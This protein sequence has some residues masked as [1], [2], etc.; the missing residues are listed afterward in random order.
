MRV[1]FVVLL[2]LSGRMPCWSASAPGDVDSLSLA[3]GRVAM[4]KSTALNG[5]GQLHN[6]EKLKAALFSGTELAIVLAALDRQQ[7]WRHWQ[8]MRQEAETPELA[9][10]YAQREDF[11]LRDRN[12]LLWWWMW[13]KLICV[14]DAYV[15]G[16]LSN[17]DAS[18]G[19]ESSLRL[20]V[21]PPDSGLLGMRL[22]A[23]LP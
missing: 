17:F 2:L 20:E 13:A 19:K 23:P 14:L 16:S 7:E 9:A 1:L 8:D 4:W 3:Q 6:G 11:Y 21:L 18:W 22:Q 15:S 5:W 12:K 10:M